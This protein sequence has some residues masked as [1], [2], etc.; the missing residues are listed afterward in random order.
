MLPA[1]HFG[2]WHLMSEAESAAPEGAG[3][4]QT[5][6]EGI[7]D[8]RIGRSAMVL[9]ACSAADETLRS[10]VAG[11]GAAQLARAVSAGARWI[12]FAETDSPKEELERLLKGF[13]ERF[14]SLPVGNAGGSR[15]THP[16]YGDGE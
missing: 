14:G 8:Y 12:R 10:F 6:A 1:V 13:V 2:V 3:V 16:A 5:R 4:L 15:R 7:M 11:R 9:Y